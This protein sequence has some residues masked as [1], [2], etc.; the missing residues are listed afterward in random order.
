MSLRNDYC[1]IKNQIKQSKNI[2]NYMLYPGKYY[3]N[4]PCR[5]ELGIVG[6]N[7]VSLYSGNLV[8]LESE[9]RGQTRK[10]SKCPCSRYRPKCI[11]D[12]CTKLVNM[13]SCQMQRIGP[14][15]D[16][17]PFGPSGCSYQK[18]KGWF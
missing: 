12:G 18:R 17:K 4:R 9:L 2:S 14:Y 15:Y 7:N 6:G 8:N 16:S 11:G 5:I 13:S 1:Y 3:N 10:L